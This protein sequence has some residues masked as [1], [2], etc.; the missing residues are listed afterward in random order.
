M[1]RYQTLIRIGLILY[2]ILLF[3]AT[4]I[5]IKKG[6]LPQGTDVPLHFIA[7]TGL[8]FL[9]IWWLSFKWDKLTPL[10]LL[11]VFVGVS[12]FGVLDELLQGIPVLRREPSVDDWVADTLGA[13]L[14]I[15]I[16]LLVRKP[17][18][19]LFNRFQNDD[20]S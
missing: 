16:F 12:L 19:R 10:R 2:W 4:H 5:P 7:Y 17:C 8:S 13:L 11:V 1:N 20:A 3:T 15:V 9:L 6:T 14:G 18:Q